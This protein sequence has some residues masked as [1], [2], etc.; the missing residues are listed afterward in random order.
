M[1][2][3]CLSDHCF[4]SHVCWI[5]PH[6]CV[7]KVSLNKMLILLK[8]KVELFLCDRISTSSPPC[9]PF[10][11]F[12]TTFSVLPVILQVVCWRRVTEVCETPGMIYMC[13]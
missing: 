2:Q 11:L 6:M 10:F 7:W 13:S 1:L 4:M 12:L 3:S 9:L 5:P 8:H